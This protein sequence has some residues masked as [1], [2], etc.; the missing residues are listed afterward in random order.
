MR[1]GIEGRVVAAFDIDASG[2][3][4][5]PRVTHSEPSALFDRSALQAIRAYQYEPYRI[6]GRPIGL[7][8]LQQEF[9]FELIE[10]VSFRPASGDSRAGQQWSIDSG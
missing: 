1:R 6:G 10:T 5:N 7:S 8:G 9:R 4:I 3:V 2:Q